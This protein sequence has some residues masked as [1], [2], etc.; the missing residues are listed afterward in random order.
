MKDP[1]G[2]PWRELA[3]CRGMD[4]NLFHPGRGD[5]RGVARAKAI[6]FRCPVTAECLALADSTEEVLVGVYGGMTAAERKLRR[7]GLTA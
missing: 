3:R 5:R 6:C 1:Q 4:P 2:I 7:R